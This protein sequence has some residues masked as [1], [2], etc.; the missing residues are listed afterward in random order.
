MQ[1]IDGSFLSFSIRLNDPLLILIRDATSS[2]VKPY[3]LRKSE[4]RVPIVLPWLQRCGAGGEEDCT[5]YE[6]REELYDKTS[7]LIY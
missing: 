6:I 3:W 1:L 7:R 2:R 4:R 5:M